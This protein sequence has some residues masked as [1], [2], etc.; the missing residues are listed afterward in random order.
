[1]AASS[2]SKQSNIFQASIFAIVMC[3]GC[4]SGVTNLSK[5]S[6][7][8]EAQSWPT[9]QG[10]ITSS[11]KKACGK[12]GLKYPSVRYEYTVNEVVL[13]GFR[14]SLSPTCS[15]TGQALR[16]N[17]KVVVHYSSRNPNVSVLYIEGQYFWHWFF[18]LGGFAII[19][20]GLFTILRIARCQK[21]VSENDKSETERL[22]KANSTMEIEIHERLSNKSL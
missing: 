6:E 1:M 17:D 10:V 8:F 20:V 18:L 14:I 16:R 19:F 3:I 12:N 11:D 22:R 5:I 4:Y 9:T 21:F 13:S 2:P 7:V 15:I